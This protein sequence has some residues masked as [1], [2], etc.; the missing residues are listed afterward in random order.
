MADKEPR[1]IAERLVYR[2]PERMLNVRV[3][4]HKPRFSPGDPVELS[5]AVTNERGEPTAAALGV[6]VAADSLF[7]LSTTNCPRCRRISF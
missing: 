2:R 6:S 1:A 4:N 3:A 7:K 5:L